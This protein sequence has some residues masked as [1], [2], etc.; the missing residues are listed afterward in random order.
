MSVKVVFS[1]LFADSPEYLWSYITNFLSFTDDTVGL[2]INCGNIDLSGID[3]LEGSERVAIHKGKIKRSKMGSTLLLGH[4]EN[5]DVA[6][7]TFPDATHFCTTA[8]NTLFI[9]PF[10]A[11]DVAA[12]LHPARHFVAKI[13][14]D[15]LP[16][17]W[18]WKN[19]RDDT[20]FVSFLR[21]HGLSHVTYSQ[22]EGL[23]MPIS[24]WIKI[25]AE[26]NFFEA[27][28]K[29]GPNSYFYEEIIP[30][31]FNSYLGTGEFAIISVNFWSR[32]DT[33]GGLATFR[34]LFMF[35]DEA[36]KVGSSFWCSSPFMM[37][38]FTR[39]ST[40][41]LTAFLTRKESCSELSM[42]R[43]LFFADR[44]EPENPIRQDI[45]RLF[46]EPSTVEGFRYIK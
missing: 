3:C 24:D 6:E 20:D 21:D 4:I 28:A 18:H 33:S 41:P 31:T 12:V 11:N 34:D 27:Q 13:S 8:S 37:K 23:L 43:N 38:W 10:S 44:A 45:G 7:Q 17:W 26:R 19:V 14:I 32:L 9:R 46:S 39:N 35:Q 2:V 16:D 29:N 25:R 30:V 40:D 15:E 36:R 5:L 1:S 22:I 42:L